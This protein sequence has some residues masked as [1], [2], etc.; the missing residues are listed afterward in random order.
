MRLINI[1]NSYNEKNSNRN[2]LERARISIILLCVMVHNGFFFYR[3]MTQNGN[4]IRVATEWS[5]VVNPWSMK[6]EFVIAKHHTI[7][8]SIALLEKIFKVVDR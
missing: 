8:V 5:S 4:F 3:M 2:N 6:L 7:E 1:S